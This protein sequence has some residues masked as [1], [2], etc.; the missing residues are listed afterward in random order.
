MRIKKN[1]IFQAKMVDIFFKI[2]FI[3]LNKFN[4]KIKINKNFKERYILIIN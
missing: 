1:S 4:N 3:F 2:S